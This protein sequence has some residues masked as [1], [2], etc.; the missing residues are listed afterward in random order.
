MDFDDAPPS[1]PP[2][3][4]STELPPNPFFDRQPT[5]FTTKSSSPPPVFS[6]DDSRES[7]DVT[8]YESPR[9]HKNKRKGAWWDRRESA[10]AHTTPEVKKT[11]F[12][13]NFDSGIYMLSDAT[14]S[15]EDL[16]PPQYVSP[17]N[18][19]SRMPIKRTLNPD[20]PDEEDANMDSASLPTAERAFVQQMDLGIARNQE[21]YD[22]DGQGLQDSDIRHIGNLKTVISGPPVHDTELP[23]AGQY[24]S[25]LPRLHVH[26][27]RNKLRR[28]V[29]S[30]FDL[31][32]LAG[33][34]LRQ[35]EI[36]ELP[37]QISRL[38]KLETLDLSLNK[39][40]YLP[41]DVITLLSPH[42]NM[43]RLTL[44]G[45]DLL[46]PMSSYR[47]SVSDYRKQEQGGFH[48]MDLLP[49]DEMREDAGNQLAHLYQTLA[50][51]EDRDG[52]VWRIRYWESLTN[53]LVGRDDAREYSVQWEVGSYPHHP[54]LPLNASNN[55]RLL[56]HAPRYIA[57]TLVSYYDQGGNILK[58]SLRLPGSNEEE[59]PIIVETSQGA[60]GVPSSPWFAPPSTSKV[61]SLVTASLY[62][63]LKSL[64][65]AGIRALLDSDFLPVVEAILSRAEENAAHGY[66]IFR[67]CHACRKEYVVARAEWIEFWS[68]GGD[69]VPLKVSVCSW[70]C[71]PSSIVQRPQKELTW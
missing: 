59:Y 60:Y 30:L 31:E 48:H 19:R 54:S 39:L 50:T 5:A 51:C 16:P 9:I 17:Y 13:R 70:G 49:L 24:R 46:Q 23:T 29:P 7:V 28:L 65:I 33:L 22:F 41:F 67:K 69:F 1:S 26:L 64:S 4:C 37:Q 36:E 18:L 57:R 3:A 43:T 14:N 10:S 44:T 21:T 15:S 35:N 53:S 40:R 32:D 62:K 11:K 8:N 71:V 25:L 47:F 6:S 38:T 58:G 2:L 27:G 52:A 45:K 63:A 12:E 68:R 42:G 66:G 55:S 34:Y 20:A 56:A 61:P